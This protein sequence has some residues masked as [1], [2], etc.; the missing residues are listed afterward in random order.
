MAYGVVFLI[1]FTGWYRLEHH[2]EC[3]VE[4][5]GKGEKLGML[6]LGYDTHDDL[7]EIYHVHRGVME[8]LKYN[9]C[10]SW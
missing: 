3:F 10:L 4:F 8:I 6:L 7:D 5:R 9:T 2:F 1:L